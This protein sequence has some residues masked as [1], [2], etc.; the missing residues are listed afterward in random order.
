[1]SLWNE[2]ISISGSKFERMRKDFDSILQRTIG[3]MKR[4][5]S[6]SASITLKLEISLMDDHDQ[7]NVQRTIPTFSH[8]VASAIQI[9]EETSGK[10]PDKYE[11]VYDEISEEFL[12]RELPPIDGQL[13]LNIEED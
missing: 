1:M 10:I 11:L 9:K 13:P 5:E 3:S 7:F 12:M 6:H 4:R 8:K 2:K